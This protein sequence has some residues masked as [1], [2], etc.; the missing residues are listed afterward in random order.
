MRALLL[1]AALALGAGPAFAQLFGAPELLEPDKAFRIAARALDARNVEVTFQIADGYYMYRERFSFA[2]ADGRALQGV[3]IPH[4]KVKVDQFFGKQETF[5]D[6]VRI[7]VP[8]SA[9]DTAKGSITL[10]VTSQG[11]SDRGICYIP[12][13]QDVKVELPRS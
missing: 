1:A 10:K 12:Q 3:Q 13:T 2:T 8:L 6:F 5:R 9:A 11:C 4:G 7:R